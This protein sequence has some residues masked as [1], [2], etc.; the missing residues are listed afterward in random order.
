MGINPNHQERLCVQ[1]VNT[2]KIY[3]RI[4]KTVLPGIQGGTNQKFDT[5]DTKGD[6]KENAFSI[7]QNPWFYLYFITFDT[8]D[9]KKI[10][11]VVKKI[12]TILLYEI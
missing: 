11:I 5:N 7:T 9:T 3:A 10:K 2:L 12:S 8:K 6:T 4:L 1:S